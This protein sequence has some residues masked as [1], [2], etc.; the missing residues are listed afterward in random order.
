VRYRVYGSDEQGFTAASVEH[1]VQHGGGF[2]DTIEQFQAKQGR[3]PKGVVTA[4]PNLVAET[5]ETRCVV[6]GPD[7]TLP[8]TNRA[9]YR[10]AAVDERGNASYASDYVAL[11]R[12]HIYTR[13]PTQAKV[14]HKYEY[15]AAAIRSI[16]HLTCF[17][18]Y[19]AAFWNCDK[20][21]F[22]LA[23]APKWLHVDAATGLM[24]GTPTEADLGRQEVVLRVA[25]NKG[26]KA[27]QKFEVNVKR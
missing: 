15:R 10:V 4:P 13:P 5:A 14:G 2:C 25:N 24:S 20:L 12:P 26:Q 7:V 3:P 6:A 21:E 22:S 1:K 8:N 9:F 23:Q 27:E 18:G 16:G 19:N 11:A 17:K